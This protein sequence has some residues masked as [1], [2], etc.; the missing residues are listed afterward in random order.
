[1]D[2]PYYLNEFKQAADQLDKTLLAKKE[3]ETETG[4]WLNSVVLRLQKRSWANKPSE[5]PQ[6]GAAIFFS[7]WLNAAAVKEDM[8]LYN[9]H[10]LKLRQLSG[11]SIASREFAAAFRQRFKRVERQWPHVST[12]FGP[13]T[14]MQGW[15]E[16]DTGHLP[17]DI[18]VLAN[19]FL[20]IDFLIDDLLRHY[21]RSNT[22][23]GK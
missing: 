23:K 21:K 22:K 19:K 9:I 18:S 20:E 2:F 7:A 6:S 10:A 1:M 15:K 17:K 3:I 16:I 11:Y 4:I 14:L 5:R 13:L 8:L 12:G